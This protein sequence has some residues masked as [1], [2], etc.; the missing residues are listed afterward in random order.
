[1]PGQRLE[2]QYSDSRPSGTFRRWQ[3]IRPGICRLHSQ[4]TDRP[5]MR[6]STPR[7]SAR[8]PPRRPVA[9]AL[10]AHTHA[11]HA[12][13]EARRHAG[14]HAQAGTHARNARL[15]SVC[16]TG[17]RPC[18]STRERRPVVLSSGPVCLALRERTVPPGRLVVYRARR[19]RA[20]MR[21]S[22][23]AHLQNKQQHSSTLFSNSIQLLGVRLKA[24]ITIT[25]SR[26]LS[27]TGGQRAL[28]KYGSP[29]QR[30]YLPKQR[31]LLRALLAAVLAP[32]AG[33]L[34]LVRNAET[35]PQPAGDRGGSWP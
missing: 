30:S 29:L 20:S 8:S 21:T 19:G 35:A 11:R 18:F 6:G 4:S 5:G 9:H 10:H 32:L 24:L 26:T 14:S 1:M 16:S 23:R 22:R 25:R 27:S 28:G 17:D 3:R 13:T 7:P 15:P 33:A 2:R 34:S 12:D 31:W